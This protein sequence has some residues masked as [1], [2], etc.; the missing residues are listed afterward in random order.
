MD[1][2]ITVISRGGI[3]NWCIFL[4]ALILFERCISFG[5]YLWSAK[6]LLKKGSNLQSFRHSC[7]RVRNRSS[8]EN[9]FREHLYREFLPSM[10]QLSTIASLVNCAPLLGLLGTVVGIIKTFHSITTFGF[11]SPDLLAEGISLALITTQS[12]LLLAFVGVLLHSRLARF[13]EAYRREFIQ[14]GE[15]YLEEVYRV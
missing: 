9:H 8:A 3:I 6:R 1:R 10:G 5:W 11:T 2:L 4:L 7:K 13:F 15:A 14:R 12:G